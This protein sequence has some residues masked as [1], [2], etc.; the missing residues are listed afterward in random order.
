MQIQVLQ[1]LRL[2]AYVLICANADFAEL[3]GRQKPLLRAA[4]LSQLKSGRT[5]APR[6]PHAEQINLGS[7]LDLAPNTNPGASRKPGSI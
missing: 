2:I 7:R 6:L 5:S 4:D 1:F 3:V